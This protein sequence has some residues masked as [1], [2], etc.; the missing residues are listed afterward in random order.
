MDA[1]EK[2]LELVNKYIADG[3]IDKCMSITYAKQ[4]ALIACDEI[5]YLPKMKEGRM[6]ALITEDF[7]FWRDVRKEIEKL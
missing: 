4:C 6:V 5:L 3:L 7:L 1:A 2:A